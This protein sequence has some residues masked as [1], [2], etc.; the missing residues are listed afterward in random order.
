MPCLS[1]MGPGERMTARVHEAVTGTGA[2]TGAAEM[3]YKVQTTTNGKQT[4]KNR[5]LRRKSEHVG[6]RT[7]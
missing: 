6:R 5:S 2:R 1:R 3:D 4:V 7:H